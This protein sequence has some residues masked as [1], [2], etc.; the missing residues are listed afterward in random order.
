MYKHVSLFL[1]NFLCGCISTCIYVYIY[2][3]V[4]VCVDVY[5]DQYVIHTCTWI[6]DPTRA[7]EKQVS[8][9]WTV[10]MQPAACHGHGCPAKFAKAASEVGR[11]M[12]SLR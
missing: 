1:Y 3:H 9:P 5:A 11:L 12:L 6:P 10:K 8:H 4:Y 2:I 7:V